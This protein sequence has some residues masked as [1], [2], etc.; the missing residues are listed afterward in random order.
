[1]LTRWPLYPYAPT[2]HCTKYHKNPVNGYTTGSCSTCS[3]REDLTSVEAGE[4]A[5]TATISSASSSIV[6]GPESFT[7]LV[8]PNCYEA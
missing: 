5:T 3:R 2:L 7:R 8:N 6:N 1:M 4:C